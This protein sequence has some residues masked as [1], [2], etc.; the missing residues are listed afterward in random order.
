MGNPAF[1]IATS[2]IADKGVD[3]KCCYRLFHEASK[4][5]RIICPEWKCVEKLLFIEENALG[6]QCRV[7]HKHDADF[8]KASSTMRT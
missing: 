8:V 4:A 6:Q 3:N 1:K 7:I 2:L 5:N